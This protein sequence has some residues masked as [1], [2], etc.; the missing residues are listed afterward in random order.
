M[1]R[2]TS[3]DILILFFGLVFVIF[4]ISDV[5]SR[6]FSH[7]SAVETAEVKEINPT[8]TPVAVAPFTPV[9]LQVPALYID[10]TIE[11]VGRK[12]DG[13]MKAPSKF[14]TTAWFN[15]SAYAGGE[16]NTVIAGH[17]NNALDTSG[18]FEH[19]DNLSLGEK[20]V[21]LDQNG[22]GATYVV[23]EM[24]VYDTN[25]APNNLIFAKTGPSRVVLI[26]CNGAWDKGK[27]SYDKRLVVFADLESAL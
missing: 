3:R 4:G 24:T 27:K 25:A 13:S 1:E 26:T 18:V 22:R 12:S 7:T 20:I 17:L 14:D 9:R 15:E 2:L 23:R 10:A 8:S 16:G 19:L 11:I 6:V 21:L 5:A